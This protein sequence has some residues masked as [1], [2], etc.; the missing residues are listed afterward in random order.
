MEVFCEPERDE[1]NNQQVPVTSIRRKFSFSQNL[2]EQKILSYYSFS[3]VR[4]SSWQHLDSE[5]WPHCSFTK[6]LSLPECTYDNIKL[7][8]GGSQNLLLPSSDQ[9]AFEGFRK[10]SNH[11]VVSMLGSS[12]LSI[13]V[14][15]SRSSVIYSLKHGNLPPFALS[16]NDALNFFL[17]L[18][19][20]LLLEQSI[21]SFILHDHDSVHSFDPLEDTM[22]PHADDC[23]QPE[24]SSESSS[25]SDESLSSLEAASK[26]VALESVDRSHGNLTKLVLMEI[27]IVEIP[28]SEEIYRDSRRTPGS[29]Q[30]SDLTWNLNDGIIRSP[31]STAPRSVWHRHKSGPSSSPFGDPSSSPFRDS[32]HSWADANTDYGGNGFGNRP[33]PT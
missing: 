32:L 12:R 13:P 10:K 24:I 31:N 19:L 4:Y 5:F 16:F 15:G 26:D 21:N 11:G 27:L 2:R 23:S 7:L 8:E 1:S 18:H 28:T 9:T 30:V 17:S 25:K 29:R 33:N 22:H 14:P 3:K 6:K 20:K